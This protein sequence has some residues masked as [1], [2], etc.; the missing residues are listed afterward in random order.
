MNTMG[1]LNSIN[2]DNLNK[3]NEDRMAKLGGI[4]NDLDYT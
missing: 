4:F 3:R 1:T 2:L